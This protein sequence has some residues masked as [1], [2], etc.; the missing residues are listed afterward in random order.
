MTSREID[1]SADGLTW[2][3]VWK[4]STT[5]QAL[6]GTL[7]SPTR[8]PLHLVFSAPDVRA[9]QLRLVEAADSSWSVTGFHAYGTT[10]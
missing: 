4:G 3:T 8:A 1:V 5:R 10:R 6:L 9:V 7:E 2:S